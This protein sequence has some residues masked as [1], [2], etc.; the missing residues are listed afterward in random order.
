MYQLVNY[1]PRG[2]TFGFSN[3]HYL[4]RLLLQISMC[5]GFCHVYI[6]FFFRME[7][8]KS[9]RG[10][11]HFKGSSW[12][13]NCLSKELYKFMKPSAIYTFPYMLT[14]LVIPKKKTKRLLLLLN[15]FSVWQPLMDLCF[16]TSMSVR[17]CNR[18]FLY[19]QKKKK[20]KVIQ[21]TKRGEKV[22]WIKV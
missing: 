6:C 4:K 16:L 11:Q 8:L 12:L 2:W 14:M 1:S 21:F 15:K 10:H 13:P 3:V 19:R 5:I 7:S 9:W 20:K 22:I 17:M 18:N